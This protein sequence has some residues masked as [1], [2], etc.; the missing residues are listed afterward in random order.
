LAA[1]GKGKN[2][3]DDWTIV[4]QRPLGAG[5]YAIPQIS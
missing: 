1:L 5:H 4:P 3:F 2:C